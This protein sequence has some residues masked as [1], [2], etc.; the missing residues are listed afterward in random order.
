MYKLLA[1]LS[2]FVISAISA[3][4]YAGVILLM[5]VESACIP[6]PSEVIMPF[7]GYLVA[8]GRFNL[9]L[10]AVAGALG[11]LLGSYVAYAVGASSGRSALERWG[12]YILITRHE[13]EVAD[14]FFDRF[15][16]AAVFIGRLLPVVRTFVAFPAGVSRMRLMPFSI[17]TFA[18]SYLWCLLLAWIGMKMGE[19]WEAIGPYFRRFD[20]LIVALIVIAI[21]LAVYYRLRGGV[22]RLDAKA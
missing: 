9:Q 17:Y 19:H 16:A 1:V 22:T 12:R 2:A 10:V 18:G 4:G 11:C 5:A 3:F 15:G 8:T 21:A 13:L 14:R 20:N 7:S 6:L